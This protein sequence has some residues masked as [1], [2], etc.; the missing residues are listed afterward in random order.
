MSKTFPVIAEIPYKISLRK[1]F[2]TEQLY[3]NWFEKYPK[4]FDKRDFE[5]AKNQ[6]RYGSHFH[7][8]LGAILLFQMTGWNSLQQKYQFKK[9]ERKQQILNDL[10]AKGLIEFFGNQK[11]KNFGSRQPPDLLVYSP[12]YTD[13]FMCEIKGPKDRLRKEQKE[14]FKELENVTNRQIKLLK[15]KT[16]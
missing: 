8:W 4:L 5:N 16:M 1:N 15:L 2:Q 10:G 13:W 7:E 14:Y 11:E 6:A 12:D 9:H 3:K